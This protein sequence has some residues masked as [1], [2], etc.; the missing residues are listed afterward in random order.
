MV[1]FKKSCLTVMR[2]RG[3]FSFNLEEIVIVNSLISWFSSANWTIKSSPADYPALFSKQGWV[4]TAW[5][6]CCSRDADCLGSRAV[7]SQG[8]SSSPASPPSKVTP[9]CNPRA[10]AGA[11]DS[12]ATYYTS[13]STV[14]S[15]AKWR[16]H[17]PRS[18]PI[19]KFCYQY[20]HS[21]NKCRWSS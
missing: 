12:L 21:S 6:D 7:T 14:S 11:L 20:T 9:P 5:N 17:S 19:L 8:P 16:R 1:V 10:A 4:R 15:S 2:N 18:L 3:V 13:S